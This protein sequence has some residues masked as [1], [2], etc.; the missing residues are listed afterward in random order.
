MY[1][2]FATAMQNKYIAIRK[3]SVAFGL[4]VITVS[5]LAEHMKCGTELDEIVPVRYVGIIVCKRRCGSM[6]LYPTY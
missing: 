5:V 6:C 1:E 4:M 2:N 3:I